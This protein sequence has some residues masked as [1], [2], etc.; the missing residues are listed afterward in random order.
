MYFENLY[1]STKR[2]LSEDTFPLGF[3]DKSSRTAAAVR[4][5][6]NLHDASLQVEIVKRR[7]R[8]EE[9]GS[10]IGPE[11]GPVFSAS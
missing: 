5:A 11:F 8:S 2:A 6:V 4:M 7:K 10:K 3:F 9:A 1:R